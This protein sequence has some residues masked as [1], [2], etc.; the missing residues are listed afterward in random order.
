MWG[1]TDPPPVGRGDDPAHEAAPTIAPTQDFVGR[2]RGEGRRE[3]RERAATVEGIGV[4]RDQKQIVP[5][6]AD[7]SGGV[8]I[9]AVAAAPAIN[10]PPRNGGGRSR[11][12]NAL[13]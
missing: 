12:A 4:P 10:V 13:A 6:L 3:N 9:V 1:R 11:H 8:P 2:V 5:A 7:G